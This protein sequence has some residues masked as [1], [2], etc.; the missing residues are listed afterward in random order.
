MGV[1]IR[2][3]AGERMC[4]AKAM[5]ISATEQLLPSACSGYILGPSKAYLIARLGNHAVEDLSRLESKEQ[6]SRRMTPP[7]VPSAD[8]L[9]SPAVKVRGHSDG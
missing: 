6:V 8:E 1:P 7:M 2:D 9:A 3:D 4:L 5:E